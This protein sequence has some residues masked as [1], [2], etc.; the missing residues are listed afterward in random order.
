MGETEV[1][2]LRRRLAEMAQNLWWSWE[3][4]MIE[5]FRDID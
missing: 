2:V 5:I 3:P 4:E 1:A